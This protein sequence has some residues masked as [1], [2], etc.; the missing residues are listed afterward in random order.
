MKFFIKTFGCRANQAESGEIARELIKNG[1][2]LSKSISECEYLIINTCTVTHRADKDCRKLISHVKRNFP[3]IK[4]AVSG[5]YAERD[6]EVFEKKGVDIIFNNGEKNKL[7]EVLVGS[8]VNLLPS[9]SSLFN[10][11]P[12]LKIEDGCNFRCSYCIIPKVRGRVKSA[13]IENIIEKIE[14]LFLEGHK[15]VVLTGINLGS[16][17]KDFGSSLFELLMNIKKSGIR[18]KIRLSSLEPMEFDFRILRFLE[19][20]MLQPHFHIPIQSGSDKILKLMGRPYTKQEFFEM[21]D[22]IKSYSKYISIGTDVICGF[23]GEGRA[24]FLEGF[25]FLKRLPLSYMHIF[26]YS[27]REGTG[28]ALMKEKVSPE[29]IKLRSKI[30]HKLDNLKREK[31]L[32][33][34]KGK[35]FWAIV[36]G[37]EDKKSKLLTENYLNLT[38]NDISGRVGEVIFVEV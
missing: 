27:D 17:G 4:I 19:D 22:R 20:G 38:K 16:Y 10:V 36:V 11:R 26:S 15:E 32:R 23:P 12:F 13:S 24:E 1:W 29:E 2:E 37:K 9:D 14:K 18:I 7:V 28:A 35:N 3:K 21:V 33:L 6:R 8:K 5:C 30:L 34:C 31:F 25:Y